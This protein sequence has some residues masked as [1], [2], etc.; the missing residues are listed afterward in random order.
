[1]LAQ[2]LAA[3]GIDKATLQL[4]GLSAEA[5]THLHRAL[6]VYTIGFQDKVRKLFGPIEHK[7]VPLNNIWRAYLAIAEIAMKVGFKVCNICSLLESAFKSVCSNLACFTRSGTEQHMLRQSLH[8]LCSSAARLQCHQHIDG[9][10]VLLYAH[11]LACILT[12]HHARLAV[13]V[14]GEFVRAAGTGS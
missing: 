13:A 9:A 8:V 10:H 6:Y 5:I 11:E 3:F 4:A 12:G 1:M 14:S 2:G 7:Q